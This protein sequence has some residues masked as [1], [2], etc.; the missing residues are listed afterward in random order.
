MKRSRMDIQSEGTYQVYY[1]N[2]YFLGFLN[3]LG[4]KDNENFTVTILRD[5]TNQMY[6]EINEY[7]RKGDYC[8]YPKNE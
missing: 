2:K 5:Y 6:I 4:W 7:L 3:K 8:W 1:S